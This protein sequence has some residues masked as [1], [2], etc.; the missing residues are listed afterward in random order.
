MPPESGM[1]APIVCVQRCVQPRAAEQDLHGKLLFVRGVALEVEESRDLRRQ[2][3]G[4]H[5]LRCAHG[6]GRGSRRKQGHWL[7]GAAGRMA[8]GTEERMAAVMCARVCGSRRA[9]FP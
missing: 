4:K 5:V 1:P 9:C 7:G 6:C 8:I 2:R 3:P